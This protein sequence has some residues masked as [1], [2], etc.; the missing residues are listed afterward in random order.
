MRRAQSAIA[1]GR[2]AEEIVTLEVTQLTGAACLA[3]RMRKSPEAN[4]GLLLPTSSGGMLA[5]IL[6]TGYGR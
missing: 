2:F 1:E 3:R 6:G 5:N 4:L